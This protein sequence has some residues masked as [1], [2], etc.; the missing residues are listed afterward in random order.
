MEA[1]I[2]TLVR[3]VSFRGSEKPLSYYRLS[4][5][6]VEDDEGNHTSRVKQ[7]SCKV[8]SGVTLHSVHGGP[9]LGL[10]VS[11][12]KSSASFNRKGRLL[13]FL[14][15]KEEREIIIG[16]DPNLMAPFDLCWDPTQT[17]IALLY[18]TQLKIYKLR[19]FTLLYTAPEV[20]LSSTWYNHT[21]V[22]LSLSGIKLCFP[23]EKETKLITITI[24][25]VNK[26]EMASNSQV[27]SVTNSSGI[28]SGTLRR[29]K[30]LGIFNCQ[31]IVF[32]DDDFFCFDISSP[33]FKFYFLVQAGLT[34]EAI[35][36]STLLSPARLLECTNFLIH[37]GFHLDALNL[38]LSNDQ[39]LFLCLKYGL[40][41]S[42]P[43]YLEAKLDSLL[44][45]S[46]N[47]TEQE[48]LIEK[49][50]FEAISI[51]SNNK[52]K[53]KTIISAQ[54]EKTIILLYRQITRMNPEYYVP[55]ILFLALRANKYDPKFYWEAKKLYKD[56]MNRSLDITLKIFYSALGKSP[57]L[58]AI[59]LREW[60]SHVSLNSTYND[61]PMA[62]IVESITAREHFFKYLMEHVID[63]DNSLS[64]FYILRSNGTALS[65]LEA[66]DM[67]FISN[68]LNEAEA[69]KGPH[70]STVHNP[71]KPSQRP[72]YQKNE[73]KNET[74]GQYS[75]PTQ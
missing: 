26:I 4:F 75:V 59:F 44:A 46:P 42:L 68:G 74:S 33:E 31:V 38:P 62:T 13:K 47:K 18:H 24:F 36:W 1:P 43:G 70:T 69:W 65:Q 7:T 52:Q 73:L 72:R 60:N 8:Y 3:R 35:K 21:F 32:S 34:N 14:S 2:P 49:Q 50:I 29:G 12:D 11:P 10:S 45:F 63:F 6:T 41:H 23:H 25:D 40:Y 20:V 9:V 27:R 5:F 66:R 53:E 15:W 67:F 22:F 28:L 71:D 64:G 61:I 19:P 57:D 55:F 37:R 48:Y 39:K 16:I 54:K 51:L 17:F 58:K 56:L 30:I